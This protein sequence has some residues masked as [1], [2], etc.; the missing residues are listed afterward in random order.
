MTQEL[1]EQMRIHFQE[2]YSMEEVKV[3]KTDAE[4]PLCKGVR[5]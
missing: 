5:A 3:L 4:C 1:Y 2:H